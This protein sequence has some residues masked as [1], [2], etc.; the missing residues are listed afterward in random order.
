MHLRSPAGPVRL[1]VLTRSCFPFLALLCLW[2]AAPPLAAQQG[3]ADTARVRLDS[4]LVSVTRSALAAAR[5]P[6][7]I[8]SVDAASMQDARAGIGLDEQLG[9]VPGLVVS[10]RQNFALGSRIVMR[11][12]GARAAFGVRGV[13]VLA[14]GIPLTMPDGQT[15]LNNLDLGS[16]GQIHVLRGPASPLFGN[17]AGGVIAVE[18]MEAPAQTSHE[19]RVTLG[20]QGRD[21]ITRLARVQ[22]RTGGRAGSVGY[23]ISASHLDAGG[24]RNYS[25]GRQTL[26]N[27]VVDVAAAGGRVSF[28]VNAADLPVAQ[29][30]GSL[31]ADSLATPEM[32]WPRNV[33]TRS[34]EAVRQVQG[35]VRWQRGGSVRSDVAVHALRRTLENPLPFAYIELDR[36]A[37]GVRALVEASLRGGWALAGG[38]D[39][40]VQQDER[41]E[42]ANQG[43][44]PTGAPRRDQQD[45]V[46]AVA[47]FAQL[48]IEHG[49]LAAMAGARYDRVN[50][51]VRD[52]LGADASAG[53]ARTLHAPS[54]M[55]GLSWTAA[56]T[57]VFGNV[58]T[59]FQ[60]PTTTEL[61]N[62]PPAPGQPCCP[63]GFNRDL[64][65]QRAIA[66]E[67]GIR[68]IVRE[69]WSYDIAA[70]VMTV[71]DALVPFQVAGADGRDFFRN[72][73][74]TRH[75]GAEFGVT[76]MLLPRVVLQAAYTWTDVRFTEHGV[77]SELDGNRVPGIVPHRA[78][79]ALRWTGSAVDVAVETSHNAAQYADDANTAEAD[80]YTLV[81]VRATGRL[82]W[83]GADWLPF[84][85]I[86]NVLDVAHSASVTVNAVGGRYYEPAPGRTLLVGVSI[87]TGAWRR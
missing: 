55:A 39:A 83:S 72:A 84:V 86:E 24:F 50:F 21:D 45:R 9:A 58:S 46:A 1:G 5:A 23:V 60:T 13:R 79:A 81:D 53:G 25:R 28:V 26:L 33:A 75:R 63:A 19:A 52:D 80:G 40:E 31:P 48:R 82:R 70:Y 47:P 16:A 71:T 27:S 68:G 87:R 38:I 4:L 73:S 57:T 7:S 17:A 74:H 14:D 42:W 61:I 78:F 65:P 67:A 30:P 77:R 44:R 6:F 37:G 69:R 15:N 54:A 18:T 85:A 36:A 22:L 2:P 20:T 41:M 12:L 51:R 56:R 76:G 29:S 32:A 11:G 35:G 59:S 10:N 8:T 49:A 3:T 62:A 43:G 34:G 66:G 64:E